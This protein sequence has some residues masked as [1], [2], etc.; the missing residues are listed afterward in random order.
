[1]T[2]LFNCIGLKPLFYK[3]GGAIQKLVGYQVNNLKNKYEI[4]IVGQITGNKE[5]I[6][7][8]SCKETPLVSSVKRF[9]F[10]GFLNFLKIWHI[11]GDIIISTHERNFFS[12]FVYSKLKRKP[13]IAWELD[14]VFWTPPLTSVKK[15]YH[16]LVRRVNYVIAISS[17]QKRRMIEQGISPDNIKIIHNVIDTEKFTPQS[18]EEE[19]EN[20]ILYVAKFTE[21]KNQLTLLKAFRYIIDRKDSKYSELKLYLVGPKS[22]AFTAKSE[23]AG[24]YY[25]KCLK[26]IHDTSLTQRVRI[27]ENLED[28]ELIELYRHAIL[29][30][31]PSLEEGFGMTL[32]EAMACGCPCIINDIEPPSEILG[33][34]G[35]LIKIR[36]PVDLAQGIEL[37]LENETLRKELGQLA[38]KRAVSEFNLE[39]FGKKFEALL[40][41]IEPNKKIK[42]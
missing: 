18:G 20:Y 4:I 23:K 10:H 8:I 16:Y 42:P 6:Q 14:H 40:L 13:L 2:I 24:S 19:K 29:F 21:R 7:L 39:K 35:L 33:N 41:K 36:K 22:G 25:Q 17:A 3:K 12:S 11:D 5:G 34:T 28:E 37:L 1:M 32:L 15:L 31:F 27:Y 9:I 38:R 26:Y 30:V